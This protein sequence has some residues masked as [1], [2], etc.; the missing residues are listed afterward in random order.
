MLNSVPFIPLVVS[1]SGDS[2]K[3]GFDD[4]EYSADDEEGEHKIEHDTQRQC[5]PKDW[6]AVEAREHSD[7][8]SESA[9]IVAP[10]ITTN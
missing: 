10:A 2:T 1:S 3:G 7:T 8:A 6:W 5:H 4:S 9:R